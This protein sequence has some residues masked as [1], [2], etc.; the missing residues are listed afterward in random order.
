MVQSE[1][2]MVRLG[3]G[4]FRMIKSSDRQR[5]RKILASTSSEAKCSTKGHETSRTGQ[6]GD[7]LVVVGTTPSSWTK[8][9][10]SEQCTHKTKDRIELCIVGTGIAARSGSRV[11]HTFSRSLS[12]CSSTSIE[13]PISSDG[14]GHSSSNVQQ[15]GRITMKSLASEDIR[16]WEFEIL[17]KS[18]AQLKCT[19]KT[20]LRFWSLPENFGI[21]PDSMD[22]FISLVEGLYNDQPF[23]NFKHAVGTMHTAFLILLRSKTNSFFTDLELL[24]ILVAA[25]CH[26]IDHP[27]HSQAFEVNSSSRLARAYN[28]TDVLEHY[29]A[30]KAL[31]LLKDKDLDILGTLSSEEAQHFREVVRSTILGTAM[32]QHHTLLESLTSRRTMTS[33]KEENACNIP[34]DKHNQEDRLQLAKMVVHTADLAGQ[35]TNYR[36]A[37]GWGTLVIAE[38]SREAAKHEAKGLEAPSFMNN[39]RTNKDENKLQASFIQGICLPLWEAMNVTIG[40][41]DEPVENLNHNCQAYLAGC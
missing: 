13:S 25:L 41:L 4:N 23:H 15:Q 19:V 20:I 28:N 34:F 35:T 10:S 18:H 14:G 29:H 2:T 27:G 39:I 8:S 12:S 22:R 21:S 38:F 33:L 9:T 32:S 24:A 40:G 5:H 3:G 37:Q 30:D 36:T 16:S 1:N 7:G 31:E 17:N 11:S 6:Y 26:D